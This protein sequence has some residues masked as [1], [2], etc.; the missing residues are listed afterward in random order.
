M[1]SPKI[2]LIIP[3][4]NE[5]AVIAQMLGALHEFLLSGACEIIVVAN[6]CTDLTALRA[7]RACPEATILEVDHAGKANAINIGF[8]QAIGSVV[9]FV[10]ADL[11]VTP[12]AIVQ[13]CQPILDGVAQAACGEMDV[14]LARASWPVRQ[15]YAGWKLNPYHDQGKFGG[16]FALS[17]VCAAGIFPIPLVTADDEYIARQIPDEKLVFVPQATFTAFAPHGWSDLIAIRRRS[18]RGTRQLHHQT[19][20]GG[21]R[22]ETASA[23]GQVIGRAWARPAAWVPVL[24]YFFAML[25]VRLPQWRQTDSHHTW[26]RDNSSRHRKPQHLGPLNSGRQMT[27]SGERK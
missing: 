8:A 27:K 13:L 11:M 1:M 4:H 9:V 24:V 17:S 15:F 12:K 25:V 20:A 26:E 21:G 23:V 16:L 3:A 14:D 2:S 6:G 5:Q 7:R 22:I 10:D 18:R 19:P